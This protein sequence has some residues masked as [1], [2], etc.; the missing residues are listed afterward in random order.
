MCRLK[1]LILVSMILAWAIKHVKVTTV[2]VVVAESQGFRMRWMA[3]IKYLC[4]DELDSRHARVFEIGHLVDDSLR[5]LESVL[6]RIGRNRVARAD[7]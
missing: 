1:L 6:L 4:L 5:A 3:R 7:S 2:V